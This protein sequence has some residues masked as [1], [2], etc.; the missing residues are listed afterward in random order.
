MPFAADT[1]AQVRL[2][3]RQGQ[4]QGPTAG[5]CPAMPRPI[6]WFCPR[7]WPMI[8]CSLPSATRARAR[9]WR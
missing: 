6:W 5:L 4:I 2:K 1:P 9:Y 7:R 3:I 8:F